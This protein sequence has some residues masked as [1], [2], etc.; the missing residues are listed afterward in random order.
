MAAN[1]GTTYALDHAR[2]LDDIRALI[3]NDPTLAQY[4]IISL[5]AFAMPWALAIAR[6]A[7]PH[8]FIL[9]E[10]GLGDEKLWLKLERRPES[11]IALL[12]GL[13]RTTAKDEVKLQVAR[14]RLYITNGPSL[15]VNS[16]NTI[17]KSCSGRAIAKRMNISLPGPIQ[18]YVI[19]AP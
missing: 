15:R 3:G 9:L 17:E 7:A 11:K 10:L 4:T 13:G 1:S 18:P 16:S 14:H 6:G 8:R 2:P 5:R 12:R 19:S